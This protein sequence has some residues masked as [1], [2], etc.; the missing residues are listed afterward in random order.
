MIASLMSRLASAR[1]ILPNVAECEVLSG[2][3]DFRLRRKSG[4]VAADVRR[5]GHVIE[6]RSSRYTQV[7]HQFS[8]KGTVTYV[9]PKDDIAGFEKALYQAKDFLSR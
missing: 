2:R 9:L 3:V 1:P 5:F 7:R 8:E 6:G 4:R